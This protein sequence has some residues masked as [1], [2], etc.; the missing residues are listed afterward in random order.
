MLTF[1]VSL[2]MPVG[3]VGGYYN[4]FIIHSPTVWYDAPPELL[5]WCPVLDCVFFV[6]TFAVIYIALWSLTLEIDN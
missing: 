1:I 2:I 4:N 6:V 5:S 3:I